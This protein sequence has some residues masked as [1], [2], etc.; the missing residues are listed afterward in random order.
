MYLVSFCVATE[1][2]FQRMTFFA[3][4]VSWFSA[5]SRAVF[6]TIDWPGFGLLVHTKD[7][8][9]H[10]FRFSFCRIFS[11]CSSVCVARSSFP[12]SFVGN[13]RLS[14]FSLSRSPP[15]LSLSLLFPSII[16]SAAFF[17]ILV[18]LRFQGQAPDRAFLCTVCRV[19]CP[20]VQSG[21]F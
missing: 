20:C 12:C 7:L 6:L 9:L 18:C 14:P 21:V 5:A 15:S 2:L 1:L 11:L 13:P 16:L 3:S 19:E 4:R 8:T 10:D 17:S